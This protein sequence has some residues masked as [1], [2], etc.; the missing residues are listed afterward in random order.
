MLATDITAMYCLNYWLANVSSTGTLY[1]SSKLPIED[2]K[3]K[4]P[5]GWTIKN[6]GE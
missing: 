5:S 4:V 3:K 2:L 1:K 6:Y